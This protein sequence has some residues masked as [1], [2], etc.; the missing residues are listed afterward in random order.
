MKLLFPLIAVCMLFAM[1]VRADEDSAYDEDPNVDDDNSVMTAD[2]A[3]AWESNGYVLASIIVLCG[4]ALIP[5]C[6]LENHPIS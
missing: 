2:E 6:W 4:I 5:A 1:P 3:P